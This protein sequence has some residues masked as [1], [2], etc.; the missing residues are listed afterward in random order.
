MFVRLMLLL[1]DF[2]REGG[3]MIVGALSAVL[4]CL[5]FKIQGSFID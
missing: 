1:K 5:S 3:K 2:V 4:N